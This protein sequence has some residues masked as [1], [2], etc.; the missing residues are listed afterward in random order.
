MARLWRDQ[1]K[2]TE[3]RDLLAPVYSWFTGGFDTLDLKAAKALLDELWARI[4]ERFPFFG[5]TLRRASLRILMLGLRLRCIVLGAIAPLGHELVKLDPVLGKAQPLQELFELAL[6]VLEPPQRIGA[7]I[8][9]SAIA[10]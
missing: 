7:I 8:V 5:R 9:E 6:F 10:A 2:R 3:A 1:G 4:S